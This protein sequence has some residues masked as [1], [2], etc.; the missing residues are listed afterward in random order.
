MPPYVSCLLLKRPAAA[1]SSFARAMLWTANAP[2]LAK[3]YEGCRRTK[4]TRD[5]PTAARITNSAAPRTIYSQ[6]VRSGAPVRLRVKNNHPAFS[7]TTWSRAATSLLS[8][9][10]AVAKWGCPASGDCSIHPGNSR[11]ITRVRSE[12]ARLPP[13]RTELPEK[14][15]NPLQRAGACRPPDR[16][17]N[18]EPDGEHVWSASILE[19]CYCFRC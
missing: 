3:L 19:D 15:L 4:T 5:N 17:F 1:T 14:L 12:H 7:Q 16:C 11:K 6:L 18:S 9:A 10:W 2:P 13:G 8:L